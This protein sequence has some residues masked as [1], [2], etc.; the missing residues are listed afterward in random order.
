MDNLHA[1]PAPAAQRFRDRTEPGA[2][3][4]HNHLV[5]DVPAPDV[6]TLARSGGV[7][8]VGSVVGTVFGL[9]LTLVVT[10]GLVQDAA[11]EFFLCTAV[12]TVIQTFLAA[13][14]SA[15]FARF[16][17]MYRVRGQAADLRTLVEVAVLPILAA[18]IIA[19]VLLLLFAGQLAQTIGHGDEASLRAAFRLVGLLLVPTTLEVAAVEGQR[20]FGGVQG[21]VAVQMVGVPLL[22]P[23]LVAAGA[24]LGLDLWGLVLL[25]LLPLMAALIVS[26]SG[27]LAA[28]HRETVGTGD[29]PGRS[30]ADVALEYWGF[31]GARGAAMVVDVALKWIDVVLVAALVST[32]QAAVYAAA[33]RFITAGRVMAEAARVTLSTEFSGAFARGHLER[34]G[35]VYRTATQWVVLLTWPL[36]LI[37]AVFAP[38]V[39]AVFGHGYDKGA[40]AMSVLCLAVMVNVA[41]GGV[42]NV[43]LMGG[44]SSW[45]LADKVV[46]LTLDVALAL[47]LIPRFGI[48][49]A[50]IAWSLTIVVDTALEFVQVRRGLRVDAELTGVVAA[51]LLPVLAVGGVAGTARLVAGSSLSV[52]SVALLA[53][54]AVYL[55]LVWR[56]RRSVGLVLPPVAPGRT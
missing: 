41:A 1:R 19:S 27:L 2:L 52:L 53:A 47:L 4:L 10:H 37:G 31:A 14:A 54:T 44:K 34:V 7:A 5:Q 13:G 24:E 43:L 8:A 35:F 36:Y 18:G 11:G 51:C 26:G 16:V 40:S 55:P 38:T 23:F 29:A 21:Y 49:G 50:A 45:L 28:L 56:L 6:R 20:A 22:R 25:W 42:E 17:P 33:S 48:L 30:R 32:A 46:A 3:S 15:G 39:L 9:V 12:F